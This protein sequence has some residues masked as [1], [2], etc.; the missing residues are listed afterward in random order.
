[1]LPQ[2]TAKTLDV[3]LTVWRGA[4]I[5]LVA[6]LSSD[7]SAK[8]Q[9]SLAN[10]ILL[11]VGESVVNEDVS[12]RW[13]VFNNLLVRG[14]QPQDLVGVLRPLVSFLKGQRII[15]LGIS[16][17]VQRDQSVVNVAV[18]GESPEPSHSDGPATAVLPDWLTEAL[19][20][21]ASSPLALRFSLAEL[22]AQPLYK[23]RLWLAI[24]SWLI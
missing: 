6:A 1:M 3:S 20:A 10:N 22:A 18:N 19:P 24:K 17:S 5:S 16:E 9:H 23:R 14:N 4:R 12:V 2:S 11:S 8:L 21:L 7:A 13:P 15:V